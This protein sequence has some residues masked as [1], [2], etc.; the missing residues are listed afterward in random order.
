M[1]HL[2]LDP[3]EPTE[4][5]LAPPPLDRAPRRLVLGALLAGAVLEV[6]LRGGVDNAVVVAGLV[7]VV[8]VLLSQR[9]VQSRQGRALAVVAVLPVAFLGLR[10]SPWLAGSNLAVALLLLSG[11]VLYSRSGSVLDAGPL[12]ILQRGFGALERGLAGLAVVRVLSPRLS[13]GDV[14]R[15]ARVARA[16]LVA[17]PVLGILVALLASADAVFA[18]LLTPDVSLG[19]LTGHLVLGSVLALVVVVIAAAASAPGDEEPRTGGFGV[20]EVA[21]MMALTAIVLGLFVVAQLVALTDA[22]ERLVTSSGLTPAEYAR[23]G[24]FQLCWAAGLLVGFLALVRAL[25][26]AEALAHP[27]VRGLGALVPVLALGLVVVSLRRMALYDQAFGL[28]MLRLWVIGAALWMGSVLVMTAVRNLGVG[29]RRAWLV[30]GSVLS[31]LVLVLAADG[32]DPEAF[33]ARH[34]LERAEQ[35][36][37]LD[38]GYL[39]DLSDDAVPALATAV[40]DEQDP[41]VRRQLLDAL[42][43][44]EVTTGVA[45]LNL[46]VAHATDARQ[47]ACAP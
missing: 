14:D 18:S 41:V 39:A 36:A 33:V 6:G 34:N 42:G 25:A 30:A 13:K 17:V 11:A 20:T 46:S 16:L 35:G 43:C 3:V 19:P 47:A 37:E 26:T 22:G 8:D 2:T 15:L 29:G 21:T 9:R 27:L 7:I 44:D 24:F 31:A 12:R 38:P 40:A 23:S 10:A 28:T 32:S 4:A 5:P 1:T 45:A